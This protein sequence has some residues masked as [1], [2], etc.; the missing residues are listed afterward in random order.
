MAL[1]NS[2]KT[3]ESLDDFRY[4]SPKTTLA[5]VI[6]NELPS[7]LVLIF[8]VAGIYMAIQEALEPTVTADLVPLKIIGT[9]LG[10]LGTINGTA[11]FISS[12]A[13]GILWSTIS[14]TFGFSIAA[15]LMTLGT[16]LLVRTGPTKET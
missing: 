1:K 3:N 16:I 14:P 10:A 12:A 15:S 7:V 2:D 6:E 8:V 11:K 13:V 9:S 5:F 4:C